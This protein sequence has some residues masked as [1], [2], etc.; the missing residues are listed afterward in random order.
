L[1]PPESEPQEALYGRLR[2]E[3]SA[4]TEA[5]ESLSRISSPINFASSK[6]TPGLQ[7]VDLAVYLHHRRSTITETH[8]AAR[9]TVRRLSGLVDATTIQNITWEL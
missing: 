2:E 3:L 9:A 8:R 6:L 7:A 5:M 1:T 4:L